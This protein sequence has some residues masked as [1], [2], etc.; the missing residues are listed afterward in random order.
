[1]CV[2]V[3]VCVCMYMYIYDHMALSYNDHIFNWIIVRKL[4]SFSGCDPA[5]EFACDTDRCVPLNWRCDGHA[6]C[7]DATDE[8]NCSGF[9]CCCF[10]KVF[11]CFTNL[12]PFAGLLNVWTSVAECA[13]ARVRVCVCVCMCVCVR[14][15]ICVFVCECV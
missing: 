1:M 15:C 12:C 9:C 14:V 10:L 2:C 7:I 3:C 13:S 4:P 8:E 11:L 5:E 6:D